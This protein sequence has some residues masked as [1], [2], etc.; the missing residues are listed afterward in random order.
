MEPDVLDPSG[1][2]TELFAALLA[3]EDMNSVLHAV[4][5]LSRRH[6]PGT[7]HCS[8]TLIRGGQ[9][10]RT[11]ASTG[12]LATDLDQAQYHHNQGPCLDAGRTDQV[13]H[14]PDMTTETRWPRYT[15]HALHIGARS[16]L[17]IPLPVENYLVGALNLYATTPHAFTD[18][19]TR[20]GESLAAHL[21]AALSYAETATTHRNRI[22]QLNHALE[23]RGIIE[24]AKGMLMMQQQCTAEHAFQQL[25]KLSMDENIKLQDLATSIVAS[26]TGQPIRIPPST[27]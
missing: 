19:S 4:A 14:L 22:E 10:A 25:R 23:S 17:S 21:T 11:V 27:P 15:P 26:A 5:D 9:R 12:Q 13:L 3:N 24:Q 20:T 8:I 16:S 7:E 6:I 2:L 18:H 1:A